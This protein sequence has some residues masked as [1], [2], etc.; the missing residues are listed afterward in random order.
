MRIEHIA[1]YVN[2]LERARKFF[3]KYLG[4]ESNEGYHNPKTNFRS[5]FLSFD[6]GARLEIMNKSEMSDQPK[7]L[8]RTGYAHIAFSVG[9]KEKVDDLTN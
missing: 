3:I 2:D 8:A 9:S 4:A 6:D 7:D 1:L 5:Y